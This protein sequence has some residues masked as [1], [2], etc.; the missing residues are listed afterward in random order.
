MPKPQRC[1]LLWL[2]LPMAILSSKT[3]FILFINFKKKDLIVIVFPRGWY[4]IDTSQNYAIQKHKKG[5]NV[6]EARNFLLPKGLKVWCTS[7]MARRRIDDQQ[8]LHWPS[9]KF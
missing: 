7:S 9:F 2:L 5:Y 6:H 3:N 4:K 1:S 8:R